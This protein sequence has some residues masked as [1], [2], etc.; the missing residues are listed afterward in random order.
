MKHLPLLQAV[1]TEPDNVKARHVYADALEPSEPAKAAFIRLG[2]QLQEMKQGLDPMWVEAVRY[3]PEEVIRTADDA[4]IRLTRLEWFQTYEGLL[5]GKPN[6]ELNARIVRDLETKYRDSSPTGQVLVLLP[7]NQECFPRFTCVG[8]FEAERIGKE[9]DYSV[10]SIL[11]FQARPPGDISVTVLEQL[12][13]L[14]WREIATDC[15]F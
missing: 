9:A 15:R 7:R 4:Q 6:G 13:A 2:A 1:L 5:L 8:L 11:W 10:A 14:K 12:K 3:V